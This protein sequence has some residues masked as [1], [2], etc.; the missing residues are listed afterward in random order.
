MQRRNARLL[1]LKVL[2]VS[3]G[4]RLP[5]KFISQRGSVT[6]VTQRCTTGESPRNA[7][8]HQQDRGS[9]EQRK[10]SSSRSQSY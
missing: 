6:A 3:W 10:V 4:Y 5:K 8:L 9:L 2:M 1:A 7:L